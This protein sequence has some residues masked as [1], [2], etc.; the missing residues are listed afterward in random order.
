MVSS[1]QAEVSLSQARQDICDKP[2]SDVNPVMSFAYI[3]ALPCFEEWFN[4]CRSIDQY[5]RLR[6]IIS[7]EYL[8][9]V[10]ENNK[11]E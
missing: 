10:A 1:S 3:D 11:S 4:S 2:V 7:D 5:N 6:Q 8:K 9:N